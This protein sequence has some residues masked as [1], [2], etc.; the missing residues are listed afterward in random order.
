MLGTKYEVQFG[1]KRIRSLLTRRHQN[2]TTIV[3]YSFKICNDIFIHA[4]ED[5]AQNGQKEAVEAETAM[6]CLSGGH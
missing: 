3:A 5:Q 4:D 2:K 1:V 6:R